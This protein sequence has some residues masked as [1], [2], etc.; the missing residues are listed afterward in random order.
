[1]LKRV[2]GVDIVP[3]C[4]SKAK[5]EIEPLMT[6]FLQKRRF[7]LTIELYQGIFD[8]SFNIIQILKKSIKGSVGSADLRFKGFDALIFIEV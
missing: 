3:Q 4:L 5:F 2:I 6:D 7:P 1:M 8:Q